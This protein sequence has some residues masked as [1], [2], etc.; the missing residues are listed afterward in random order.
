MRGNSG[1]ALDGAG[2]ELTKDADGSS[3][4]QTALLM[5]S[6]SWVT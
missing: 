6:S 5:P 3:Q 2:A 1:V 4:A